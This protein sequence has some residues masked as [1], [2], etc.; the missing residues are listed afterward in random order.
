[1]DFKCHNNILIFARFFRSMKTFVKRILQS[2][3]GFETYLY[4]FA[5][6]IIATLKFNRREKDFL[7]FIS[8]LPPKGIVLDI[9]ANIGAMTT[10]LTRRLKEA[11]VYAFEPAPC[12]LRTLKKIVRHYKL[13]NVS[14]M[15][16][17][18]GNSTGK[19]DMIV[20]EEKKIRMHGLS[21]IIKDNQKDDEPGEHFTAEMT[22]LDNIR[23]FK[24]GAP[25]TG[26][27]LDVEDYEYFVLDG[28]RDLITKH[29]PIIYAELWNSENRNKCF[30]LLTSLGYSILILNKNKL[31][32]FDPVKHTT[33]NFFF[34]P[35]S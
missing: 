34:I 23:A 20:P 19:T 24:N 12:N 14:I 29:H 8:L 26:I 27:K 22:T 11:S 10:H 16:M 4:V 9:G 28:G 6:Y 17:A 25:V 18:L 1:M 32:P 33:Q 35:H 15:E 21:H 13:N 30:E 7:H 31:L 5:K 2:L 3:L